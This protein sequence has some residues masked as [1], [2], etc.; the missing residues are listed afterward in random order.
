MKLTHHTRE[1]NANE[2]G[3]AL[4]TSAAVHYLIRKIDDLSHTSL[5]SLR[6][7]QTGKQFLSALEAYSKRTVWTG[8]VEGVDINKAA[9][10]AGHA[11]DFMHNMIILAQAVSDVPDG[12]KELFWLEMQKNFKRF[13]LPIRIT[14]E[15][16]LEMVDK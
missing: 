6:I 4:S 5:F 8:D 3:V 11:A 1:L 15:G 13:D 9:E 16:V 2:K 12:Q 7:K 10:Q 14:P